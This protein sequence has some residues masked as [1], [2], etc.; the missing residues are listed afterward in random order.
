[1]CHRG[2]SAHA[3][4]VHIEIDAVAAT[5]PSGEVVIDGAPAR[6]FAGW[7]ELLAILAEVLP[8]SGA[9]SAGPGLGG[10]LDP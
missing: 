4:T 7:L 5:P 1:M 10:Q 6:P 9:E 8:P 2:G 3:V